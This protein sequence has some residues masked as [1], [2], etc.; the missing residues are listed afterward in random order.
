MLYTLQ[1][2]MFSAT[3]G[4]VITYHVTGSTLI[5]V[6]GFNCIFYMINIGK[7]N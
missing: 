1:M 6:L 7:Q 5:I 3:S 4:H 2:T